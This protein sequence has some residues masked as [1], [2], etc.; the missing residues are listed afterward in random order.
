MMAD[1]AE[2]LKETFPHPPR[3]SDAFL[4]EV[5]KVVGSADLKTSE[6]ELVAHSRDFWSLS[7]VWFLKGKIPALPEA[8]A[9]PES[10]Q[11]VAMHA[12]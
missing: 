11:E 3:L 2:Q 12:C 9:Y 6:A 7:Q 10:T 4:E 1:K 8:V 5:E